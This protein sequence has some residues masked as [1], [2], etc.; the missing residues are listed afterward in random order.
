MRSQPAEP[1]DERPILIL[2]QQTLH[3]LFV[4][5]PEVM[6]STDK[7]L[8]NTFHILLIDRRKAQSEV[9]PCFLLTDLICRSEDRAWCGEDAIWFLGLEDPE[10]MGKLLVGNRFGGGNGVRGE[11]EVDEGEHSGHWWWKIVDLSLVED[12]EGIVIGVEV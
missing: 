12:L 11:V 6:T 3:L 4:Q 9:L 7:S 2:I 10:G 5:L 1:F 8:T